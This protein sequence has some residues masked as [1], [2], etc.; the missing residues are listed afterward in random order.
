MYA[1]QERRHA[2]GGRRSSDNEFC[3][4]HHILQDEKKEA[5]DL[6]CGKIKSLKTDHE[7]DIRR[8]DK[9]IDRVDKKVDDEL[10]EFKNMIV[11]K[12]WFRFIIGL[13]GIAIVYIGYQQSWAF[14]KILS[15]QTDFSIQLNVVENN[16]IIIKEKVRMLEESHHLTSKEK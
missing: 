16:Q 2:F 9:D 10:K 14:N 7:E 3:A 5:K 15:N 1:G 8:L 11:G 12:Y 4:L 13:I 6:V